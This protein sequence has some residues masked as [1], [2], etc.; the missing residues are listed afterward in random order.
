VQ[1]LPRWLALL[2]IVVVVALIAFAGYRYFF[3][4]P[5]WTEQMPIGE[6]PAGEPIYRK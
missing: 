3:G 6:T 2:I 5:K 1:E 4:K